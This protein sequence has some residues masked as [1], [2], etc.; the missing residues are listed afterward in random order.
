MYHIP[1][2]LS[3]CIDGLKINPQGIYVDVTFGGGGHSRAILDQL[4]TGKLYAFD[5][6]LDAH[7][8]TWDDDRLVMVHQN[9][10]YIKNALRFL[11]VKKVDG[12]LADLGV[13]SYQLD[14]VSRGFTL[15][16]AAPLDMRMNQSTGLT[17]AD[18]LNTYEADQLADVFYQY[19]EIKKSRRLA[20]AVVASRMD[21]PF[22]NSNQLKRVA[23]SVGWERSE[24]QFYARIFQALRIEVNQEMESLKQF[25]VDAADMLSEG[26]R[27]VV[28][29]YHS[30]ED[31]L[32]K[33]FMKTGTF[34][35][36]PEVDLYGAYQK[37][38]NML[39]SK[40]VLA[41]EEEIKQNSR[42][43]SVRLRIAEK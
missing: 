20:A 13:S 41:D 23:K 12:V 30:L 4:T 25:L 2:L 6:D 26:G 3:Q 39:S 31:R 32:V 11:G 10:R 27:L 21:E 40:A 33:H 9:Y 8:N 15:Q 1:V 42:A 28:M 18:V 24:H 7:K 36:R 29:S 5:R 19:G 37:P 22:T 34:D 14:E 35:G 38:L 16:D 17:A 43:S